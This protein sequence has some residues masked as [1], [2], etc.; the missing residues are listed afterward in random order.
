[1]PLSPGINMRDRLTVTNQLCDT[2]ALHTARQ[3]TFPDNALKT[4]NQ[5]F[6]VY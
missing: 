1:M 3:E 5:Q 2:S 6:L 4:K